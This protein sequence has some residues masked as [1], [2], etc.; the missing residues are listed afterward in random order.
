M[1]AHPKRPDG[2]ARPD[3]GTRAALEGLVSRCGPSPGDQCPALA[4]CGDTAGP[5]GVAVTVRSQTPGLGACAT[6]LVLARAVAEGR[7]ATHLVVDGDWQRLCGL[8]LQTLLEL[9]PEAPVFP[10]GPNPSAPVPWRSL[11]PDPFVSFIPEPAPG[12]P[13]VD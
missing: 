10:L 5:I 6:R 3:P 9:A 2:P 1:S 4:A 8:C 7:A 13:R 11:I 12:G